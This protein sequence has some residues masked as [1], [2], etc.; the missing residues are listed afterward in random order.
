M[1]VASRHSVSMFVWTATNEESGLAQL[2]QDIA[3]IGQVADTERGEQVSQNFINGF[4]Y[5]YLLLF[6]VG[7]FRAVYCQVN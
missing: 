1:T 5:L 3:M 2:D 7:F 4:I 6:T